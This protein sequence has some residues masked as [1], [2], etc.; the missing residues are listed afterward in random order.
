M[1]RDVR[2]FHYLS[3]R[4]TCVIAPFADEVDPKF[5]KATEQYDNVVS[6]GISSTNPLITHAYGCDSR[7]GTSSHQLSHHKAL[8]L[9]N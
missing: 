3:Y 5:I 7:A 9:D 1:S 8:D 2:W 6:L 4:R